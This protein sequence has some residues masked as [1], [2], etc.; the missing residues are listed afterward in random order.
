MLFDIDAFST[1]RWA[2]ESIAWSRVRA[3]SRWKASICSVRSILVFLPPDLD[4]FPSGLGFPSAWALI[5]F[6]DL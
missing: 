5:S 3:L 2:I 4:F 6:L 1:G